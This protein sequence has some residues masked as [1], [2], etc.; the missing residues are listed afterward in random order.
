MYSPFFHF[1]LQPYD[2][3]LQALAKA[4]FKLAAGIPFDVSYTTDTY[5]CFKVASI[6][7]YIIFLTQKQLFLLSL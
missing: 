6:V 1:T 4:G 3:R 5:N 7:R 2:D